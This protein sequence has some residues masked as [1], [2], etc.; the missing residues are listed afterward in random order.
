MKNLDTICLFFAFLLPASLV[1]AGEHTTAGGRSLAMGGASVA[2]ND[3]WSICNNQAGTAWLKAV[4]VGIGFENRFLIK[5]LMV[6][7]LGFAVPLKAGTFGLLVNRF[8]NNQYNELEAG[9]CYA[10]KFGNH[11]S[12]GIQLSYLRIHIADDYGNKNLVSCEIGLMYLA[13]KHLSLGVQLLNPVPVKITTYPP[14]QL[15]SII[16]I[17]LSYRF[18][19]EFLTTFETEK[20]LINPLIIRA[21]AEYYFVRQACARIGISTGPMS[22]TFG[23]GLE[24]GQLR[25]EMA[26]EYHQALGF[27]PAGSII[28]SFK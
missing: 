22:F 13:D 8:G 20:D 4:C 6:E 24:F 2:A 21:G 11:F 28:Y 1:A 3:L 9:L 19:D 14:E 23:F 25:V 10:R 17:G 15:P 27:S 26:S 7:Q 5:E 18:S 16:C 12:V